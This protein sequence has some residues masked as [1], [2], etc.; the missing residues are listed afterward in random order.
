MGGHASPAERKGKGSL[1]K[2]PH[3]D[4]R[5]LSNRLERFDLGVRTPPRSSRS[6]SGNT[7]LAFQSKP[8]LDDNG[9][10]D[11]AAITIKGTSTNL[12]KDYLRLTQVHPPALPMLSLTSVYSTMLTRRICSTRITTS[13]HALHLLSSRF[14]AVST[15]AKVLIFWLVMAYAPINIAPGHHEPLNRVI[16]YTYQ[17]AVFAVVPSFHE[18]VPIT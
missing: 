18:S 3:M 16:G 14:A 5:R 17:A 9:M 6:K 15:A 10:V 7:D 11:W 13:T 1:S 2:M 8:M 12:E 4:Q